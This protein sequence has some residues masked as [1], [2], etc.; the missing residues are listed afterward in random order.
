MYN[1]KL[2]EGQIFEVSGN[3]GHT[4]LYMDGK[5]T[6]ITMQEF[7]LINWRL[8]EERAKII[9]EFRWKNS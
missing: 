8:P 3:T 6:E 2:N 5:I 7:N 4:Y 9:K 1:I